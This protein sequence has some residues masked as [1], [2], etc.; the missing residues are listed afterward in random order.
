VAVVAV[1]DVEI[2]ETKVKG[3]WVWW[4]W[5]WVRMLCGC[6]VVVRNGEEEGRLVVSLGGLGHKLG[7]LRTRQ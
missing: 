6:V 7:A 2:V 5:L 4:L 1:V 3:M